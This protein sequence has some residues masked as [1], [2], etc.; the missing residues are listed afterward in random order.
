MPLT[1]TELLGSSGPVAER[2]G[3][4][5][6]GFESRPEQAAMAEAVAKALHERG[7]LLV[8]AGTGVGKSFAYLVPAILRCVMFGEK[9]VVATATIA[10][11]EQLMAK[12]IPLLQETLERWDVEQKFP[13]KAVLAKGRGNY[14]STRRLQIASA[15]QDALMHDAESRVSLEQIQQWAYQT[16]D[17]TLSSLPQVM[18]PEVWEHVRS[19]ADNCMGRK[20]PTYQKCFYQS[21]RRELESANLIVCNH[22]LFFADLALRVRAGASAGGTVRAILPGY[23]HVVFDEAHTLEDAA[24]EHFGLSLT[25]ARVMRLLRTLF[26][27]RRRKGYLLDKSLLIGEVGSVDRA[28]SLVSEAMHAAEIFFDDL[29]D[30]HARHR[31]GGGRLRTPDAVENPL[32]PA[33]HDLALRLRMLKDQV[34]GEGPASESERFELS[35]F[36]KRAQEIGDCAEAMV[37]QTLRDFVYWV[38]AEGDAG[39]PAGSSGPARAVGGRGGR[40]DDDEGDDP[41]PTA[42]GVVGGP[43][44]PSAYLPVPGGRPRRRRV[45]LACAPVDVAAILRKH[46]FS[47]EAVV[48]EA[49]IDEGGEDPQD[50]NAAATDELDEPGVHI[51]EADLEA[52]L[53]EPPAEAD[54]GPVSGGKARASGTTGGT[55]PPAARRVGIVLTSATLATRTVTPGGP[56][57]HAETAFAHAMGNLGVDGADTLQL[58][59]PF[60]YRRQAKVVVD[61]SVPDPRSTRGNDRPGSGRGAGGRGAGGS[62]AEGAES[63]DDALARRVLHHVRA[64]EGGA[65]VLFTSMATLGA[66]ADRIGGRLKQLGYPMFVQGRDGPRSMM[67]KG[68]MESEGG[69]LLGAASFWQGVDVRGDRLRNVIITRLPF[70]PPDRPLTQARIE[71]IELTGAS[72]FM[73]D[74]LPRAI[75]KFKQGFGRLIRSK[76]DTGRVV[77]LD[78]RIATARYGRM[79]IEALPKGVPVEVIDPRAEEF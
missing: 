68:F 62:Q 9:V 35:S 59:S 66:V 77:V 37:G 17:G 15:R 13:L 31:Q 23:D 25:Q 75:I 36:A 30:L 50:Q 72:A 29:L 76:S 65:F 22:A 8:E 21:A 53:D 70:D 55:P 60:D 3:A 46:L 51:S 58:G 79:F 61:L 64:T 38:E 74:S 14:L 49:G 47:P 5:S 28:L 56:K 16:H 18:R 41:P 69:V 10:L 71:R 6:G 39:G 63:F 2:L 33:M 1:C 24:S 11:Q 12:D 48:A 67:L 27:P 26:N 78:P 34:P 57:E 44:F 73:Q 52:M 42:P 4:Q 43:V 45:T 40:A 54:S 32:T 7:R 20:C 19:D